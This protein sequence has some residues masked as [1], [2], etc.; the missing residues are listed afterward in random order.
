MSGVGACQAAGVLACN[1]M[2]A[3]A[4]NAVVGTPIAETCDGNDNDCDGAIDNGFNLGMA[5]MSGVGACQAAGVLA[6][7]GMGAATC[8]AVVGT[9]IAE[10]CD[11]NDNDCDGAIDNGFNLGM[12]CMSGV[13]ACQAA[14]VLA[15][16]GKGAALCDAV[17]G[18][19]TAELCDD[20]KDNDCDGSVDEDCA[21][22]PI[23][24]G[25]GL[26]CA[27]QPVREP[28]GASFGLFGVGAAMALARRKRRRDGR[29]S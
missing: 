2:G 8:N 24:E 27:M 14:G 28:F 21:S 13:G 20:G 7:D 25:G 16:D 23:I 9:P 3:A 17:A 4:C 29:S 11:G 18:A 5:C 12:A 15:C 10:T 19:P 6:C 22:P 26:S 1:G